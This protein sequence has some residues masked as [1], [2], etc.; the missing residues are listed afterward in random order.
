MTPTC[1]KCGWGLIRDVI[2][3]R[4]TEAERD[5]AREH[6]ARRV[7]HGDLC[8]ACYRR[9]RPPRIA[10]T[11]AEVTAMRLEDL[12]WMA[13][14]GEHLHGAADRLGISV[15]ALEQFL[16]RY[17]RDVLATLRARDPRDWN[18]V[19]DGSGVTSWMPNP[20]LRARQERRNERKR[21]ERRGVAA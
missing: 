3:R 12:R 10:P 18:K 15:D 16:L 21:A 2:W 14:T 6:Q 17:D 4:M 20:A 1:R 9:P 19:A 13:E 5:A 7:S 11:P 8:V